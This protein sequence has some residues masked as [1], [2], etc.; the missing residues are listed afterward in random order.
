VAKWQKGTPFDPDSIGIV[1]AAF[2]DLIE[3]GFDR[4]EIEQVFRRFRSKLHVAPDLGTSNNNRC[5][6][7]GSK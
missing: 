6:T 2:D 3:R 5:V 7:L 1:A 4:H